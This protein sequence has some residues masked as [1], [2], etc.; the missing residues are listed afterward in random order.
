MDERIC[1]GSNPNIPANL[2]N[3]SDQQIGRGSYKY[4]YQKRG[5]KRGT[6]CRLLYS[7]LNLTC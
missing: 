7:I 3:D 2:E 5:E 6:V 4:Q 1:K